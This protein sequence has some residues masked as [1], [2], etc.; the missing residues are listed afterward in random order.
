MFRTYYYVFILCILINLDCI[1]ILPVITVLPT[2]K[3]VKYPFK[4]P[5]INMDFGE[6][7]PTVTP[8]MNN[9]EKCP[10]KNWIMVIE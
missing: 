2:E 5:L 10:F 3:V 6:C 4:S 9:R 7:V 8:N 1:V